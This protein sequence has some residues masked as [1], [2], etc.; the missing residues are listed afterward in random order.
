MAATYTPIAS[1]TLGA[2]ATSVTFTNIPQTYTDLVIVTNWG[3]S[4]GDLYLRVN[5]DTSSLYSETWI[6]G[7]GTNA[8]SNRL[9][10]RDGWYVDYNGVVATTIQPNAVINFMNYSNTT[11]FKTAIWREN[12]ASS[13]V[14]LHVGLYRSTSAITSISLIS[15]GSANSLTSGSTFNLY[16]IQA[17]NA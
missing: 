14:E 7:N 1:I 15:T 13:S 17:G 12:D 5:N 11:T 9:S 10:G 16:G 2:V 8:A 6:R 3:Q 4:S